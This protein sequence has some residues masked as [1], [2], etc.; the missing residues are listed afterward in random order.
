[1]YYALLLLLEFGLGRRISARWICFVFFVFWEVSLVP[2]YF[3]IGIWG[4]ERRIYAAVKFFLYTM[5]GSA[6]M[7]VAILYIYT[8]T[9]TFDYPAILQLM[10]TG[11]LTLRPGRAV[12]ICFSPSSSPSR[13]KCRCSRSIRGC[14]TRTWR[15]RRPARSCSPPSCSRWEPTGWFASACRCFRAPRGAA[16]AGL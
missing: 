4:H 15:L 14:R 16:R 12:M 6:L 8:K 5:A 11:R 13:S 10:D 9:D 2:M 3:L 7:L 1:M